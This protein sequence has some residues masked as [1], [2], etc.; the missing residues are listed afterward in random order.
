MQWF[1]NFEKR[2]AWRLIEWL[3]RRHRWHNTVLDTR[4]P[5]VPFIKVKSLTVVNGYGQ[6]HVIKGA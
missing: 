3:I 2:T 5:N 1:R 6:E 4:V